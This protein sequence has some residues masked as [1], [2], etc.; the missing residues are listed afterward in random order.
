MNLIESFNESVKRLRETG[1]FS[2]SKEL[3]VSEE[4][5]LHK[6]NEKIS[7]EMDSILIEY[8]SYIDEIMEY[9]KLGKEIQKEIN[10]YTDKLELM[11]KEMYDS[12]E[13]EDKET[14]DVL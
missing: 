10:F 7:Y 3:Q 6:L 4:N 2:K 1:N 5:I 12:I 14:N 9:L 13:N 11:V 8:I